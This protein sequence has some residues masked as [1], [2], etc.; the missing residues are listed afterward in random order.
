MTKPPALSDYPALLN[1]IRSEIDSARRNIENTRAMTYWKVGKIVHKDILKNKARAGYGDELYKRLSKDLEIGERILYRSVQFYQEYPNLSPATQLS[2]S[3]Y[4]E[5][6]SVSNK[7]Q[8][9]QLQQRA[10]AHG[11]SKSELRREILL[12]RTR[13][14]GR[15][16]TDDARSSSIVL[17]PSSLVTPPPGQLLVYQVITPTTFTPAKGI[18]VVDC[19]F[20][21]WAQVKRS[22]HSTAKFVTERKEMTFTYK[23]YVEDVI[24]GDTLWLQ[25][26]LGF[27]NVT[28]Q[29]VRLRGI[30]A[31]ELAKSEG[32]R[33]K[34]FVEKALKGAERVIIKSS[35]SD[36]YDRYLVDIFFGVDGTYLNQKLLE[37][38]LAVGY[39]E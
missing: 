34:R 3:H 23:A 29:K 4:T 37:E 31:P 19:G 24:D 15:E 26:D 14:E 17:R 36:K 5:L 20:N 1:R 11:L 13:D 32:Q 38:G 27:G 7:F 28:R 9:R 6:L 22:E 16:T 35:K 12:R 2:W 39:K 33:A 8:R 25:I 18:A 30:D 21:F 10:L